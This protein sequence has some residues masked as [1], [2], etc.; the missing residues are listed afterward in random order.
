MNLC[1]F[2]LCGCMD[3][4][5]EKAMVTAHAFCLFVL[6]LFSKRI[7]FPHTFSKKFVTSGLNSFLSAI[8]TSADVPDSDT[9]STILFSQIG[10]FH[11]QVKL[12][13]GFFNALR[14]QF[15]SNCCTSTLYTGFLFTFF[16]AALR[17]PHLVIM[18]VISGMTH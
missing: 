15:S 4:K 2:A 10:S 12:I 18:C 7:S 16:C 14:V 17:R 1:D 5:N 3:F 8:A 6:S 13:F 11:L 9:V